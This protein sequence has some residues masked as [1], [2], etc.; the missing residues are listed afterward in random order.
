MS[1]RE[2]NNWNEGPFVQSDGLAVTTNATQK[3]DVE[4]SQFYVVKDGV[5]EVSRRF[6]VIDQARGEL[7]RLLTER[8]GSSLRIAIVDSSGREL[9]RG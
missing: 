3:F 4:P 8:V 6:Q 2:N 5:T 1:L 9:L 7:G